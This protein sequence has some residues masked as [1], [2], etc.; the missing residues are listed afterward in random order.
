VSASHPILSRLDT[1]RPLLVSGDP[2]ASLRARGVLLHAPAP[3][4]RLLREHPAG[5]RDHYQHDI[6]AGVDVL[7]CLTSET[8]PRALHEI[9]MMFRAAALTGG[10]I[11]IAI[12]AVEMAPR[13]LIVA[14]VLGNADV[15]SVAED[16]LGEELGTHAARLAAAGCELILARGFGYHR[17]GPPGEAEAALVRMARRAALLSGVMTQL[18]TW[19]V[20]NVNVSGFTVDGEHVEECARRSFDEGAQVV[21]FEIPLPLSEIPWLDRLIAS[22]HNRIGFAP[23]AAGLEPEAWAIEG[24]R[25]IDRGVRVIGGGPGTTQRHLAALSANLRL[26]ERQS[27][28][29]RAV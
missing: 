13:P 6:A 26:S 12:D 20:V 4:A 28:W 11:D 19:A 9:G 5:V 24:R 16:R 29:P 27:L 17:P 22:G 25:L 10:A 3:L 15:P 23:A 14:G 7:A 1:G 18:P 8:I 21:L 2:A